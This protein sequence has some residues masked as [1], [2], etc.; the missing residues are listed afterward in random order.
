M[1]NVID[2]DIK[3]LGGMPVFSETR[4]PVRIPIEYPE[5]GDRLDD[6]LDSHPAVSRAQAIEILKRAKATLAGSS[7]EDT[8]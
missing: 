5:A 6:F 2:R 3:I 7:S 4:V 1:D 8:E